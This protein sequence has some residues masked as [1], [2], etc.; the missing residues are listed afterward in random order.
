MKEPES[1]PEIDLN[2]FGE[3]WGIKD[4]WNFMIDEEE[5]FKN[6]ELPW[7]KEHPA[8][9]IIWTNLSEIDFVRIVYALIE[10]GYL[11]S[12]KAKK[13]KTVE[14]FAEK[15]NF[16]LSKSWKSNFSQTGSRKEG[17]N[18]FEIFDNLKNSFQ[19]YRE[20]KEK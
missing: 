16:N 4:F 5:R 2:V 3:Y 9:G 19:K 8:S 18:H 13:E 20:N 10:A 6:K 1:N 17:Y 12:G 11:E 15:L 14:S 7:Q